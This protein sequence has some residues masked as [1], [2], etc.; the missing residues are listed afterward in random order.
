M[1]YFSNG[2]EGDMYEEEYCNHCVHE[3]EEKGCAVMLA[4][5]IHN[6]KECN[7]KDSILHM[8]IPRDAQGFNEKCRMFIERKAVKVEK[9]HDPE[10]RYVNGRLAL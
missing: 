7:K 6:Y 3:D 2:T 9:L 4:H 8:L 5:L 10:R 1:G